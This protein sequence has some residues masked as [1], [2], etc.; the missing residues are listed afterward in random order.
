MPGPVSGMIYYRSDMFENPELPYIAV[1][2]NP[3]LDYL[4]PNC[5]RRRGSL[6]C[7]GDIPAEAFPFPLDLFLESHLYPIVTYQNRQPA[8]AFDE[9]A[10]AYFALEPDAMDGLEPARPLY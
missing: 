10:A 2:I 6:L 3:A 4:H 7:L 8:H 5:C 1:Q 9:E